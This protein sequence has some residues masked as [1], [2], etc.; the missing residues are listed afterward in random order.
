M[1]MKKFLVFIITITIIGFNSNLLAQG[2]LMIY[3]KRV[4][5]NKSEV[6]KTITLINTSAKK[7]T[8]S[9]KFIQRRMN[10][11]GS[12]T[13]I[14]SPG[15]GQNFADAHL[16][17]YPRVVS[18]EP[19]ES[20]KVS[21]QRKRARNM[22]IGEYR[23]HLLFI[24]NPEIKPLTSEEKEEELNSNDLSTVITTNVGISIPV[25]MRVGE[26]AMSI[27]IG[28]LKLEENILTFTLNREGDISSYGDL[29][30]EHTAINNTTTTIGKIRGIAVYTTI[31]TR[32]MKYDLSSLKDT[33]LT[34]GSLKIV[35]Q[36]SPGSK[37]EK[38]SEATILLKK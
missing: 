25:I 30:F 32:K 16:R 34:E 35:Y 14:E 4:V 21:V 37:Q 20:Q 9:V 19:G 2:N 17:I 38:F 31:K 1:L 27:I 10:S 33:Y 24:A 7:S 11:D 13:A 18:L 15:P 26:V 28:D 6:K 36:T 3:P 23:S 12:F 8:F 29:L 22:K 5:F